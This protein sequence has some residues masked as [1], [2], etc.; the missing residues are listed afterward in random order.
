MTQK[1][2]VLVFLF[3]LP[4]AMFAQTGKIKGKVTE[5]GTEE[6][7]IGANVILIGTSLGAA[8]DINGE[9]TITNVEAGVHTLKAS[10]IG[11]QSKSISN[12]RVNAGLTLEVNFELAGAGF[13]VQEISVVA[14]RPLVNKY[15]TNANRIATSEDIDALPVRG[16]NEILAITPGVTYQDETVFVKGGR[17]DEVG[18]Y[19]EGASITD[20]VVGGRSVT[21]VQD[22]VE[23]IQV[24]SGGYTAEY[25]GANSGIIYTQMKTGTSNWKAT[26][27]YITDNVAFSGKDSRYDGEKRLGANWYGYSDMIGTLSGPVFDER[28]KLFL[29]GN[30]SFEADRNPQPYPGINLGLIGDAGTGDTIDFRYPAGALKKIARRNFDRIGNAYIGFQSF[31]F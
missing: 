26:V 29:L 30:Y 5:M 24:Q 31:H 11:F 17:Q 6:P 1:L 18:F 15:A 4:I 25:G 14:E 16:L 8:T 28:I 22:A 3:L 12:L 7:L 10:F 23:E 9:Y 13:T 27:E 20:P 19:L 21:I 2:T